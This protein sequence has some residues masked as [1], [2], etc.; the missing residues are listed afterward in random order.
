MS[1]CTKSVK[2][3]KEK[4]YE[5]K[6]LLSKRNQKRKVQYCYC[7]NGKIKNLKANQKSFRILGTPI[8]FSLTVVLKEV[9][10]HPYLSESN[11]LMTRYVSYTTT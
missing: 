8:K 1:H 11:T 6:L 4:D 3:I 7:N 2:E 9:V 10:T 5:R